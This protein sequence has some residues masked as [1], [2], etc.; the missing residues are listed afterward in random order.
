MEPALP[1]VGA[2]RRR[3][4]GQVPPAWRPGDLRRHGAHGAGLLDAPAADRRAGQFRLDGR[5][6]AGGDAL[7]RGAADPRGARDARRHRARHRSL[8]RQ[9]RRQRA[10][11]GGPAGAHPQP[12][13]Q[14][15][16]RHRRRHGDQRAAAQ[17]GR[18]RRCLPCDARRARHPDRPAD[19][20]RA[21]ARLP[22][23]RIRARPPGH[24]GGLPFRA[25][26][27]GDA[28]A[29]PCRGD[30]QEPRGDRRHRDPLSGEQ[31]ADDR[32][33]RRA[34]ARE[35]DRGHIGSARR[36]RPHRRAR[37]DRAA[38]R[39]DGRHRAQPALPLLAAAD[40]LRRQHAGARPRQ[41]RDDGL[42]VAAQRLPRVPRRRGAPA[43][44]LRARQGA[45]AR[46][47]ARRARRRGGQYR[48]HDRAHPRRARPPSPRA[49]G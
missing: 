35:A 26:L 13:G 15:R 4:D 32:E 46:P 20:D 9:L 45:R 28:R 8:P 12:A 43:H 39:R 30:P 10:R 7:H 48:R 37:G 42:A 33:D 19:R 16:R 29:H 23:R 44:R 11:A 47:R 41:A 3:R 36:I 27:G 38:P 34:G 25:R 18:G 1:Q 5:R 24:Q 21:R 40:Q 17:S 2:H 6:P 31:G 49:A 22:D 14:R